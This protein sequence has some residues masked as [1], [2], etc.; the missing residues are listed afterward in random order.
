MK[1]AMIYRFPFAL[2]N[3]MYI[4]P[5]CLE[6][7]RLNKYLSYWKASETTRDDTGATTTI[8][9]PWNVSLLLSP[10][11]HAQTQ[12]DLTFSALDFMA[13]FLKRC[14][15]KWWLTTY[16][17]GRWGPFSTFVCFHMPELRV[18]L[19]F[20]KV[21]PACSLIFFKAENHLWFLVKQV[22]IEI[23]VWVFWKR[24]LIKH[25]SD[26]EYKQNDFLLSSHD[27]STE[28]TGVS[29]SA[30]EKPPNKMHTHTRAQRTPI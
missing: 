5:A 14:P 19:P 10:S 2:A 20:I 6:A 16:G 29:V 18:G 23:L 26:F 28:A 30:A 12:H 7:F 13:C 3:T 17:G 24:L 21:I 4:I 11:S 9:Q 8:T 25:E 27:K 1:S 22:A 15:D